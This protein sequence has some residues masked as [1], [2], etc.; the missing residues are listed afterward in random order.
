MCFLQL[1]EISME[2]DSAHF[3]ETYFS[4]IVKG[5]GFFKQKARPV[6]KFLFIYDIFRFADDLCTFNNDELENNY[7]DIYPDK[8]EFKKEKEDP[9]KV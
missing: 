6:C 4:T 9:C 2:Y 8:L 1:I 7:N 3:R 5:R